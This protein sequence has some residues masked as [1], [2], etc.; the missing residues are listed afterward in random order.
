MNTLK[1]F[2]SIT[3]FF[4]LSILT[5]CNNSGGPVSSSDFSA[6]ETI[7]KGSTTVNEG[8]P[9]ILPVIPT[10]KEQIRL[11]PFR[12]YTFNFSNT[13]F[14]KITSVD[15]NAIP[16]GPSPGIVTFDCR[17]LSIY[18]DNKN[19]VEITCHSRDLD[20]SW[21]TIENLSSKMLNLD[22]SLLGIELKKNRE[23]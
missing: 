6:N 9:I 8:L 10:Y 15:I 18:G 20:A 7:N 4:V 23:K 3:L 11:K 21:L 1:M 17:D 13:K 14:L 12:S 2:L 5:G 16:S 19:D 22:V